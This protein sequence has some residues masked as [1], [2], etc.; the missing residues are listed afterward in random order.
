MSTVCKLTMSWF[1][2]IASRCIFV[3]DISSSH[4]AAVK[5]F[6]IFSS[7]CAICHLIFLSVCSWP[8]KRNHNSSVSGEIVPEASASVQIT[9][10][11]QGNI[12]LFPYKNDSSRGLQLRCLSPDVTNMVDVMTRWWEGGMLAPFALFSS[13]V[14]R[15]RFCPVNDWE[16]S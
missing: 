7:G 15:D 4:P 5:A 13:P 8:H 2:K 11:C 1:T 14:R 6:H 12:T 16:G 9:F 3:Q 10:R